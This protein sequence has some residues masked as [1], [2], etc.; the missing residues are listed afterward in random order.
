MWRGTRG[1]EP[2][3]NEGLNGGVALT[4]EGYILLIL[5]VDG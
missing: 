4:V 5:T 1:W 3:S 2:G